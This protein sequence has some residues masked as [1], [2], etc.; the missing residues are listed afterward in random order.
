MPE[1]RGTTRAGRW[2]VSNANVSPLPVTR[3]LVYYHLPSI[4]L[5]HNH[6]PSRRT[7]SSVIGKTAHTAVMERVDHMN[8]HD[9][10]MQFIRDSLQTVLQ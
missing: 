4:S 9:Y 2:P 7:I 5:N 3:C 8:T 1:S 10:L 6:L